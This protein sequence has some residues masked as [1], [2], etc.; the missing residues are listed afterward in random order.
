MTKAPV[1]NE[2]LDS[3]IRRASCVRGECD[4]SIL[5]DSELYHVQQS[6]ISTSQ[7]EK[8]EDEDYLRI[9][10]DEESVIC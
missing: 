2:A 3:L 4:G 10:M 5:R 7:R 9:F 8:E 1:L 6:R